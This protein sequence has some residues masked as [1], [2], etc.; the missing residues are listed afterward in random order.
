MY[1]YILIAPPMLL[2]YFIEGISIM[3]DDDLKLKIS[4]LFKTYTFNS[5]DNIIKR[6]L[7][8]KYNDPYKS[9]NLT[10]EEIRQDMQSKGLPHMEDR[11]S[12]IE[13]NNGLIIE[14]LTTGLFMWEHEKII[15]TNT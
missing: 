13:Q 9:S 11:I 6:R 2:G 7:L 8:S 10:V 5:S 4:Y 14:Y 3:T 1:D 15:Q 12:N